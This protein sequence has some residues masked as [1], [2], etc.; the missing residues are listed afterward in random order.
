MSSAL[1]CTDRQVNI[2]LSANNNYLWG[3]VGHT[4][5]INNVESAAIRKPEVEEHKMKVATVQ[6]VQ[7]FIAGCS[8]GDLKAVS[9]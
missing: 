3:E 8:C 5:G 2:G 4:N 6:P 9:L 1:Y 7:C